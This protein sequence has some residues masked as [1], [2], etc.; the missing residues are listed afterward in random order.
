MKPE[1]FAIDIAG[2]GISFH[3]DRNPSEFGFKRNNDQFISVN[4]TEIKL[5]VHL[6]S[7]PEIKEKEKIFDSG[8]TWALYRSS[9]RYILQDDS[10]ESDSLLETLVI[11]EPDF[12]SGNVYIRN[13]TLNRVNS[14]DLLGYPLNQILMIILLS[15]CNGII[16]H[17]CGVEDGGIGYLF[18][19]RS[20][21]GKSTIANLWSKEGA[22]ILNDD[23]IVVREK[24][25][26]F[27][28]YGTPW[29]GD[30]TEVSSKALPIRKLFFLNHGKKNAYFAV[31]GVEAVSMLLT[32]SFLPLWNQKGMDYT[33]SLFDRMASQLPCYK[34]QFCP[35]QEIID[36]VRKI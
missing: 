23:R 22:T 14:S 11:L 3:F 12:K 24:D 6:D 36:F 33:L 16:I 8:S 1:E 34:L 30:F 7:I 35:D 27:W 17:A 18:P 26:E 28:M 9:G 32:R 21:Q 19:G 2:I 4:S 10:F 15:R 25:G 31:K 29:H 13:N 20:T 5:R